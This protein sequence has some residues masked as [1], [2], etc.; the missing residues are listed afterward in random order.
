MD[1]TIPE[2][3]DCNLDIPHEFKIMESEIQDE[4][5]NEKE[6]KSLLKNLEQDEEKSKSNLEEREI[7]NIGTEIEISSLRIL[8]ETKLDKSDW[9]N[10][11][12]NCF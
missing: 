10:V 11:M 9:N 8:M 1:I 5:D 3:D 7:I 2:F 6:S 4:S 12:N